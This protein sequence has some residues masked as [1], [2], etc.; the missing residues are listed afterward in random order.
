MVTMNRKTKENFVIEE[1][2]EED[3]DEKKEEDEEDEKKEEKK[4]EKE[5]KKLSVVVIKGVNESRR[6]VKMNVNSGTL[7]TIFNSVSNSVSRRGT[8]FSVMIITT[9]TKVL[10]LERSHSFHFRKVI[11]DLK[12]NSININVLTSLYTS[13]L[14]TIRRLFFE[15]LPPAPPY[16]SG[17]TGTQ[18]TVHI[19]PGGH[20]MRN[21]TI[22]RT[23]LRELQEE[24]SINFNIQDLWFNKSCIF[25]VL[26][27]DCIIKKY[28]NNF[29]FPAKVNMSSKDIHSRFKES[30]HTRNPLFLDISRCKTLLDA[31]LQVQRFM[32]L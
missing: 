15:F 7:R 6:V 2:K 11:R 16:P 10:L 22:N 25:N 23:L 30:R 26:I 14:E 9:D 21:E 24:T 27:Y 31:F 4:E 18:K 13:E 17:R 32:V 19:F 28:F 8:S 3:E 5:K 29:V 12:L 20:P 1:K